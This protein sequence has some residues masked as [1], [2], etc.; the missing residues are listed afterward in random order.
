M[1]SDTAFTDEQ[2]TAYLDG[3][4]DFVSEQEVTA[5]LE[6]DPHL[7]ARLDTL[8]MDT[9]RVA[10][11]FDELLARAPS[12]PE[13][14]GMEPAAPVWLR[15]AVL[16]CVAAT[17][18]VCL[19]VGWGAGFMSSQRELDTWRDFVAA[20]QALYINRTLVHI[21]QAEDDAQAELGRVADAIGRELKLTALS[22]VEQLDYKRAQILGFEGRPLAQITFLSKIGAPIALCIIRSARA[23]TAPVETSTMQGMASAHWSKGG[24]EFLLIGGAD[25]ALIKSAADAFAARL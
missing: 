12:A 22:R 13:L 15:S 3:E 4:F 9:D 8:A 25:T 24:Y 6:S 21:D 1:S 11:A 10:A 17:A 23:D 16:R 14:S 5:A 18:V 2:L 19:V 7:K 20:Y